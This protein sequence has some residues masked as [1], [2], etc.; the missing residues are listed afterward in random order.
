MIESE[1]DSSFKG[2]PFRFH[3]VTSLAK[4]EF[5]IAHLLEHNG[6][7]A[8]DTET[9]PYEKYLH[10]PKAGLSPILSRVR[11]IQFFEGRNVFVFDMRQLP[12]E[13]FL[14]LL[15]T[16]QFV[17][18]YS[19]FD[20]QYLLLWGA[21]PNIGCTNLIAKL[22]F[23]AVTHE[24]MRTNLQILSKCFLGVAIRKELQHSEWSNNELTYEQIEY[25]AMDTVYTYRLAELLAPK[26]DALGLT[27][28][29]KL[30]K[31]AQYPIAKMQL[32]GMSFDASRHRDLICGWRDDLYAAKNEVLRLT[33]IKAVT[34]PQIAA[35][36]T[37][38]LDQETYKIWPRTEPSDTYPEG[39]LKTD[40]TTFMDFDYLPLVK[41]L[42]IY[43]KKHTL[44]STF[45]SALIEKIT[46]ADSRLRSHYNLCGARTGRLSS[47]EPNL[48]NAPRDSQFRSSFIASPGKVLLRADY[49]QIEIRV[50][51]ELS[52]DKEMLRAYREGIDIHSL[53]ASKVMGVPMESV[54]QDNRR[55]A[56][57]INFGWMFGMGVVKFITYSRHNYGVVM[58]LDD[59]KQT[60]SSWQKTYSGYHAYQNEQARIG[61]ETCRSTTPL[62]KLRALNPEFT[63][64]AAMNQP[65]QGGA[66]EIILLALVELDKRGKAI[67]NTVHDE[68]VMEVDS[69]S[70]EENTETLRDCMVAGFRE[71]FPNGIVNGLV[72]ISSGNNWAESK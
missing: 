17:G 12:R 35:W 19:I 24:D 1:F 34:S 44:T 59:T 39:Q 41:P 65:V 8:L 72:S 51:A 57:S 55:C 5:C 23:H 26:L 10:Y 54:T 70:V 62:G 20:L 37:E 32:K 18:H 49:N 27:R 3:Y 22:I 2:T 4:A 9:E 11:L 52:Q 13:V 28:I 30:Y 50:G 69:D 61:K 48:Q 43:K 53:T 29:Y 58:T 14:P 47:S 67:T 42:A 25:A 56:K 15:N 71:V 6:I 36:L 60:K 21:S 64:G 38:N 66:A 33:G 7:I 16:K 45:G 68:I 63:F 40:A 31:A 46:P